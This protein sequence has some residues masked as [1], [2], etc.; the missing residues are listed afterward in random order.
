MALFKKQTVE[1]APEAVVVPVGQ[2]V[3]KSDFSGVELKEYLAVAEKIGFSNGAVLE[4]QLREFL[5]EEGIALYNYNDVA[6][7]LARKAK[8]LSTGEEHVWCWKPLRECDK[9][10]SGRWS[11]SENGYVSAR[12][13]NG[14]VPYP[15]LLTV[16]KIAQRFGNQICFH[17][18][19]YESKRPD[20][21]LAVTAP[22][23]G[24]FIVERWDEPDFRS[25]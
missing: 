7:F 8:D 13:Y 21:F 5:A 6:S 14:P 16:E 3:E 25:R 23:I 10:S 4:A 2:K 11:A 1:V 20:P 15:V 18:S 24:W 22:G 9:L 19:D 12:Q 17:V